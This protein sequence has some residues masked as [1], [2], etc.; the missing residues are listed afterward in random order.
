VAGIGK[1]TICTITEGNAYAEGF[2]VLTEGLDMFR[3]GATATGG[4]MD[5]SGNLFFTERSLLRWISGS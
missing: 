4:N 3:V 1:G 2:V 5:P